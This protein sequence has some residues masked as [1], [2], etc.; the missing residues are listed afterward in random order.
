[1]AFDIARK[2]TA[3]GALV[4]LLEC[5]DEMLMAFVCGQRMQPPRARP[6]IEYEYR[7]DSQPQRFDQ[8]Q[9]RWHL[10][11]LVD[12]E[13]QFLIGADHHGRIGL[14]AARRIAEALVVTAH[15]RQLDRRDPARRNLGGQSLQVDANL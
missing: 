9:E 2:R 8:E 10:R 4:V 7:T 11:A 14:D 1:R 6:Q 12:R 5:R 3:R 13:M 15:P